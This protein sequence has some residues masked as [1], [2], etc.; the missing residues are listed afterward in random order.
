MKK[1][2]AKFFLP[3][4]LSIFSIIIYFSLNSITDNTITPYK[5]FLSMVEKGD[6]TTV[7][8]NDSD[9]IKFSDTEGESYST[10]NPRSENF[11]EFLL[12]NNIDVKEST[13]KPLTQ[14][15]PLS[16]LLASLILLVVLVLKDKKLSPKGIF[17]NSNLNLESVENIDISFNDVAGNE[18]AKE[19]LKDVIDFLKNPEKY[20]RYGARMPKGVIFYGEPGTGKTLLAKAVAGEA[21]V[22]FYAVSGSD[23]V[24]MYVGVGASRIRNLFSKARSHGKAVIFIDEIDAIG[25]QRSSNNTSGSSEEKDQTLNAL[26]TEMSGFNEKEG[27]VVIAATNRFDMLDNALLRP[28]RFDRH[29]EVALPDVNARKRIIDL[30]LEKKP[31]KEIDVT[32]WAKKTAYFSGAKIENFI[33]EAA[34][35]ACRENTPSITS[36]HLEKA[37]STVI[38]G[39]PKLDRSYIKDIDRKITAYHEIGHA[40]TSM[41]LIPNEEISKVSI[42]PSTKGAGGYTLSIPEDKMYYSKDYLYNKIK[43][44]LGGRAA[45]EILLGNDYITTGAQNDFQKA[46]SLALDLISKYG[47]GDTLGLL[48]YSELK[49]KGI[50]IDNSILTESKTL[51]DRLYKEVLQLLSDN[52][53]TLD[54]FS[55][56]L[57]EK[58]MLCGE[59]LTL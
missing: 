2:N 20:H 26:L 38:A 23:F 57:L 41:L 50:S 13:E 16:M 40:L 19:N 15:I 24:Q 9:T 54:R 44:M 35:L 46:T 37:Y 22:P 47:M 45:E 17:S 25:K 1:N 53:E 12:I 28:G 55:E 6:I 52:A 59:E 58:E 18:E 49:Q 5:E 11:K 51:L 56:L 43:V 21:N 42:I 31:T 29:I 33:N 8:L 32:S 34:I 27:I 3:I 7:T 30:Y 39:S 10:Y 4:I 14:T 48:S 36:L